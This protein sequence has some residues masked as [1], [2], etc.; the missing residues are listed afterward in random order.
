M[1]HFQEWCDAMVNDG[2]PQAIIT[3]SNILCDYRGRRINISE[4]VRFEEEFGN[5]YKKSGLFPVEALEQFWIETDRISNPFF[6]LGPVVS[7]TTNRYSRIMD[8]RDFRKHHLSFR[9]HPGKISANSK[10]N[11]EDVRKICPKGIPPSTANGSMRGGRP[12]AWVTKSEDL[13]IFKGIGDHDEMATQIRDAL[14][15]AKFNQDDTYLIEVQYPVKLME[16]TVI[17]APT[18]M[19]GC[20]FSAY[21]SNRNAGDF[22]RTVN[23]TTLRTHLP[24]AVHREL[25][26][27]SDFRI[28]LLGWLKRYTFDW[29]KLKKKIS[30]QWN[31]K[32]YKEIS[33][34]G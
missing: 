1:S 5:F 23:L 22:G 16:K 32:S 18:F 9:K 34:H 24:E 2:S 29:D 26:F 28:E 19:D 10:L 25:K 15:L 13:E 4:F 11:L 7:S 21:R 12:F 33:H 6:C 14:G 31:S 30:P 3:L 27:S 8:V 20:P 17:T